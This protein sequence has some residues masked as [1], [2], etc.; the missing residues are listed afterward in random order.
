MYDVEKELKSEINS[1]YHVAKLI[2]YVTNNI[3]IILFYSITS[4]HFIVLIK[5]ENI[6]LWILI[7]KLNFCVFFIS[8]NRLI[9]FKFRK[10]DYAIE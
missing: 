5:I 9:Y 2:Y 10:S 3:F 4:I 1:I 6:L 8:K 7:K